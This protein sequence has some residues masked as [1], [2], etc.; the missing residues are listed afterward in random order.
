MSSEQGVVLSMLPSERKNTTLCFLV[1]GDS[2]LL[3]MK[4]RGFGQ[5][6]WNGVGGKILTGETP[7]AATIRE[8]QEEIGVML[9]SLSKVALLHFLFP[10]AP[11]N[12][13]WD[14]TCHVYL[15][16]AW[17]GEP[18]ETDEMAPRWFQI[19]ALPFSSMWSDDAIWLP[20]V[21]RG[22]LVTATFVFDENQ[23]CLSH[24]LV[25]GHVE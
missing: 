4:K 15:A 5:G 2:V 25:E 17:E 6:K 24:S 1:R 16:H 12:D 9:T 8:T 18:V 11:E 19:D 10:D 3:A 14:Q 13:D 20:R 21:L 23:E 7:E 22:S